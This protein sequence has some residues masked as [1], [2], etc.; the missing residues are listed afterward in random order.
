MPAVIE[1]GK[2]KSK[3]LAID[4]PQKMFHL[5]VAVTFNSLPGTE[6]SPSLW[7]GLLS[8]KIKRP[9]ILIIIKMYYY[10]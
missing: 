10:Y 8:E 1:N 2:N 7:A 5:L 6:P 3:V 9:I 4:T